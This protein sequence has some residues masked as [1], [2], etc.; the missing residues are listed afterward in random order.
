MT[1]QL[2]DLVRMD[3]V[4]LVTPVPTKTCAAGLHHRDAQMA[5]MRLA[6]A[7]LGSAGVATLVIITDAAAVRLFSLG[8]KIRVDP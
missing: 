1:V 3:S 7:S 6:P 4:L 8:N 5:E 2:L